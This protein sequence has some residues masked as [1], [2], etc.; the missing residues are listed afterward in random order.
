M[1]EDRGCR[2]DSEARQRNS[3]GALEVFSSL[4]SSAQ[5]NLST[6]TSCTQFLLQIMNDHMRRWLE[7]MPESLVL[8]GVQRERHYTDTLSLSI[9][10]KVA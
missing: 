2:T 4:F 9:V 3:S 7:E 6:L 8:M 10:T 1:A 5:R